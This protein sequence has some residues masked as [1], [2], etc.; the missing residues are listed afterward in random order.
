MKHISPSLKVLSVFLLLPLSFYLG[1]LG[2]FPHIPIMV[3][4]GILVVYFRR[5]SLRITDRSIIYTVVVIGV[6]VTLGGYLFANEESRL[7]I[8]SFFFRPEYYCAFALL[9]PIAMALFPSEILFVGMNLGAAIFVL[10]TCGDVNNLM[11]QNTRMPFFDSWLNEHYLLSYRIMVGYVLFLILA[12]LSPVLQQNR[13]HFKIL[14]LRL[15]SV[16]VLILCIMGV[17]YLAP[18]IDAGIREIERVYMRGHSMRMGQKMLKNSAPVFGDNVDLNLP[19]PLSGNKER[20]KIVLRVKGK[21]PP[22]YL[23]MRCFE[24]Y[25]R[26]IWEKSSGNGGVQSYAGVSSKGMITVTTFDLGEKADSVAQQQWQISFC[27]GMRS[28]FLPVVMPVQRIRMVASGLKVDKMG[29]ITA[30]QWRRDAGY[31]IFCRNDLLK[32]DAWQGKVAGKG[33]GPE[34]EEFLSVPEELRLRLDALLAAMPNWKEAVSFS[35]KRSALESYFAQNY[36]YRLGV[37]RPPEAGDPVLYFLENSKAGHCE[38]F[39]A[40]SVLLLRQAGIPA[41]Y[42]TG[43]L[44]YE[45]HPSGIYYVSRLSNAHAWLEAYNETLQKWIRLDMTPPS[46]IQNRSE[47]WNGLASWWDLFKYYFS[48][49][50]RMVHEGRIA[51][52][53]VLFVVLAGRALIHPIGIFLLL[54]GAGYFGWYRYSQAQRIKKMCLSDRQYLARKKYLQVLHF[55]QKKLKI[56]IPESMSAQEFLNLLQKESEKCSLKEFQ[57]AVQEVVDYEKERFEEENI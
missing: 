9:C 22:E 6:L 30:E 8:F 19:M 48:E 4:T 51:A 28:A 12:L 26:G 35:Q 55:W 50:I 45:R 34:K 13:S 46:E 36:S 15:L 33:R 56:R 1:V 24:E 47:N 16:F 7:G 43:F 40:A 17:F 11:F 5:Q 18:K 3:L 44:C 23:R 32:K 27:G 54:F 10:G 42:V 53:I 2:D 20:K 57:N 38:L 25:K 29:Q 52:A 37:E 14:L 31:E 21:Q 41:R 49:I 39:A